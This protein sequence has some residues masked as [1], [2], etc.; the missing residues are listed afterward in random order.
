VRPTILDLYGRPI[1]LPD[2]LERRDAGGGWVNPLTGI[3]SSVDKSQAGYYAQTLRIQD[4]ELRYLND[5]N[6]LTAAVVWDHPNEMFREGY[7]LSGRIPKPRKSGSPTD[8]ATDL[9]ESDIKNLRDYATENYEVDGLV[10]EASGWG[11]LFGGCLL[12]MGIN[13][14]RFPWEPVDEDRIRSFD[15]LS[16]VDRRYAYVQSQ[17]SGINAK[18]YGTAQIYLISN[19]IAGSGWNDHGDVRARSPE[20]LQS[21]GAQIQ[22]VHASRVIRLDGN[23]ADVQSRQRLA[24]WSWSVLQRV[25]NAMRQFEH[26]FDSATYLLSDAS[27]GVFKMA[28]FMR[29]V[30]AGRRQEI[31]DRVMA[32]E[33]T[34]SVIRGLI[35][36]AGGVDGKGGESYERQ[37]TPLAGIADILEQM[38]SRFAAAA[39]MPQ[40][41]LFGRSPAGLSATGDS[42]MRIWYDNV[43]SDGNVKIAP[44]IRRIY[45][46]IARSPDSPIKGKT[47]EF[48]VEFRPLWSP[49]DLEV[50]QALAARATRDV[51]L[52]GGGIVPEEVAALTWGDEYP[53][54]NEEALKESIE[55]KESFDPH[56]NDPPPAP[57]T[58]GG[59]PIPP[60]AAP[61]GGSP[62]AGGAL[63]QRTPP[64]AKPEDPNEGTGEQLSGATPIPPLGPGP[65]LA[66]PLA[67]RPSV[68]GKAPEPVPSH[69]QPRSQ[70]SK[71]PPA[72]IAPP[73]RKPTGPQQKK[74]WR[75]DAEG[76]D[77]EDDAALLRLDAATATR[78]DA[79]AAQE[80]FR[81]LLPDYPAK[82]LGWVLAVTWSGPTEVPLE[83]I[84]TSGR[85][86]WKAS[87]DGKV[88]A[89][90]SRIE[91]GTSPPVILVK[92]LG[93]AKWMIVDG[94]HRF[95][96][97]E[98]LGKPVLAYTAEMGAAVGPWTTMHSLQKRG[99]SGPDASGVSWA[100]INAGP[101]APPHEDAA[102]ADWKPREEL[103]RFSK[104][105]HSEVVSTPHGDAHV[106]LRV[107]PGGE[108]VFSARSRGLDGNVTKPQH[109]R[110]PGD[111]VTPERLEAEA[112]GKRVVAHGHGLPPEVR[113]QAHA[114]VHAMRARATA[115]R[116]SK[117]DARDTPPI[118]Q[119]AAICLVFDPEGRL[120]TVSRPEPPHEMAIPGGMVDPGEGT[121]VAATRELLEECGIVVQ[122]LRYRTMLN[123]PL[124][125]RPVQVFV[126]GSFTG[127]AHAA[128][129]GTKV[130]WMTV[131]DLVRQ[132]VIYRPFLDELLA[133]DNLKPQREYLPRDPLPRAE[134]P[135]SAEETEMT[136][137]HVQRVG[138]QDGLTAAFAGSTRTIV[139]APAKDTKEATNAETGAALD[140]K[141]CDCSASVTKD[142]KG[143]DD[144]MHD[145]TCRL[146]TG[147]PDPKGA[148]EAGPGPESTAIQKSAPQS[149]DVPQFERAPGTDAS[150]SARSDDR[151]F[152][153]EDHPR[154]Q[155]GKF[156]SG[157][158]AGAGGAAGG[159]S[160]AAGAHASAGAGAAS[161]HGERPL[162]AEA[163]KPGGLARLTG[164]FHAIA[165]TL[166]GASGAIGHAVMHEVKEKIHDF[167]NAGVGIKH[168]VTGQPVSKTEKVAMAHVALTVASTLIAG[169]LTP[170]LHVGALA[171]TEAVGAVLEKVTDQVADHVLDYIGAKGLRLVNL[172][173]VLVMDA[174]ILPNATDDEAMDWFGTEL[175]KAVA[176]ALEELGNNPPP[177]EEK[178]DA[179]DQPREPAG[180]PEG[181][182]FASG[183]AGGATS[184]PTSVSGKPDISKMTQLGEG[185]S[186]K[187]Y[188]AGNGTVIKVAKSVKARGENRNEAE[189]SGKND[190]LAKVSEHG[191]K[192]A[193]IRME[194]LSPAT[195]QDL[196]K[197]FGVSQKDAAKKYDVTINGPPGWPDQKVTGKD[198]LFAATH[199]ADGRG[200]APKTADKFVA[201]LRR[202]KADLPKTELGD[203]AYANQWGIDKSG[204]PKIADYAFRGDA[205]TAGTATSPS[206]SQDYDENQPRDEKGQFAS[207][208][209]GGSSEKKEPADKPAQGHLF[210][211]KELGAKSITQP[212]SDPKALYESAREANE[213]QLDL[214][215]RGKG[216]ASEIGAPVI[217]GDQGQ[218]ADLSKPGPVVMV[219]PIKT[220]ERAEAKAKS[221]YDG[222]FER[223]GDIVRATVA[224]DSPK[225]IAPII[226]K[227]RDKGIEIVRAKDSIN[228]PA[229]P[230][231]YRDMKLNVRYPNGH[232]GELQ[233]NVKSMV[234]AKEG[235]GHKLY[236][237][238]QEIERGAKG[239]DFTALEASQHAALESQQRT[240]YGAAWSKARSDA[241]DFDESKHPRAANGQFGEGGG[242]TAKTAASLTEQA[243]ASRGFTYRPDKDAPKDGYIVSLP[244]S[245]G[246]NH[247][248]DVKEMAARSTSIVSFNKEVAA[249]V[250][251]HL[252]KAMAHL[253]QNGDHF[254]GGYVEKSDDGKPVALHLDVNEHHADRDKAI[255]AGVARNQISIW[256]VA[257]GEEIKTGG[258]GRGDGEWNE[259]D[260][261]RGPGGEFG[262]GEVVS[263]GGPNTSVEQ[264]PKPMS[265]KRLATMRAKLAQEINNHPAERI[266]EPMP[267]DAVTLVPVNQSSLA[268]TGEKI[269]IKD[270]AI[271]HQRVGDPDM[272]DAWH[273]YNVRL[274]NPSAKTMAKVKKLIDASRATGH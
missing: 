109:V 252:D 29:A 9:P 219:G 206:I 243:F 238:M 155:S 11:R 179:D 97:H 186:R 175:V 2:P 49:T 8:A 64:G 35:V 203:L 245:E 242:E 91:A 80:V 143:P 256:D 12:V 85:A 267:P 123:S 45:R 81:Q 227:I 229:S 189:D 232:V 200:E 105:E 208:E 158:G 136:G 71:A 182:Q 107:L 202:L 239:R 268:T 126:A 169:H 162:A 187:V 196:A 270:G 66:K 154:D 40:T 129:A 68:A 76:W 101:P 48:T 53:A 261:P 20:G 148:N 168:F 120:L 260:H 14:G 262:S 1:E 205:L 171:H 165:S 233:F 52:T 133:R 195:S 172:D 128:E 241:G 269:A 21:G 177:D 234:Q 159:G 26:A 33:M 19:A 10:H 266:H 170:L 194:K 28:G 174:V 115:L 62:G 93:A 65:R 87:T 272:A 180:T 130:A 77:L 141:T 36:D 259:S 99:P 63:A 3:G 122:D 247:V 30:A 110:I 161:P 207:S 199:A 263:G 114:L 151:E 24:G 127:D 82:Y 146:I 197:H 37:P 144:A 38:K 251:E 178:S 190:L 79:G 185:A 60:G 32:M 192:F 58:P 213:Q 86:D 231:G 69:G 7:D 152:N 75:Y 42:D 50:E 198:W 160:K 246:F 31:A 98:Q 273:H 18:K 112:D 253:A 211:D 83:D 230:A 124:D 70:G 258:T 140:G 119:H 15:Y 44:K 103:G 222:H 5:S 56:E 191:D 257:K 235:P 118:D 209:G 59:P 163:A 25:Y 210:S 221:D 94:H 95:L 193:W 13:D 164:A 215:N 84:D 218:K 181:G 188:D 225:E 226:Q 102:R 250:Q 139:G 55:A 145:K 43:R 149:D 184:S 6:D 271:F 248:I 17:Y 117:T 47:V 201:A 236:A 116:A 16:L 237:R 137:T 265:P 223:V 167:K 113:A 157:G 244:P 264:A 132:A 212:T 88:P 106:Q 100:S 173:S 156:T 147:T 111:Q 72:G 41:K 90:V 134:R 255:G 220:Q 217:R 74:D 78:E 125:G 57:G 153:E 121:D 23:P 89:H 166:R 216:I 51:A 142:V 176:D 183:S 104:A 92:P 108:H 96:G 135:K 67:T 150:D 240:L 228:G 61:A 249:R 214:L 274:T 39:K 34:R 4:H 73:N 46:N 204:K 27:Q 224:V 54:L 131:D 254:F 22:L 138:A